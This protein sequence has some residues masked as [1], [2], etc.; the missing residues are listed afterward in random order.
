MTADELHH[1]LRQHLARPIPAVVLPDDPAATI[2]RVE[3]GLTL[4]LAEPLTWAHEAAGRVL[5][6]FLSVV[7]PDHLVYYAT[8]RLHRWRRLDGTQFQDLRQQLGLPWSEARPRHL[9]ELILTD[10]A[11]C[12]SCGFRYREI[13]DARADRAGL[14]EVT[15]PQEY[16][17]GYLLPI[18]RTALSAGPLWS[19]IGGYSARMSERFRADAFDVAWAWAQRYRGVDIQD[20]EPMAWRVREGLPG[21]NWLTILGGS[22]ARELDFDLARAGAHRWTDPMICTEVAGDNLLIRAGEQPVIADA[23]RFEEPTAY[24]EVASVARNLLL[25]EPPELLGYFRDHESTGRWFR[26]FVDGGWPE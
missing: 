1:S 17:P 7:P 5:D 16:D 20:P 22:L 15:L 24:Q 18:A 8:S 9:F 2:A 19:G 4:Y 3:L 26:R 12:P 21:I 11:G 10:D 13:D 14:I 23:H 25:K 6:S